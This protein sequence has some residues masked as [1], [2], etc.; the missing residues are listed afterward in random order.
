MR[1]GRKP[2]TQRGPSA[3]KLER[4]WNAAVATNGN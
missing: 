4:L 2:A 1:Q 3:Q